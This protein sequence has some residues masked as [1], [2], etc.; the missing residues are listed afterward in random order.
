[1]I[2]LAIII[3]TRRGYRTAYLRAF[4]TGGQSNNQDQE[5]LLV[6]AN[7]GRNI[8]RTRDIANE[9]RGDRDGLERYF[10]DKESSIE[11]DFVQDSESG[12]ADGVSES[13][14]QS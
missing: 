1:M 13:E 5:E 6:D 9:F 14:L 2:K 10:R 4:T 7:D 3:R 8:D 11:R 12:A